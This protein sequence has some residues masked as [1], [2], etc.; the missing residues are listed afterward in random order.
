MSTKTPTK[1]KTKTAAITAPATPP[2]IAPPVEVIAGF[3]GFNK[4]LICHPDGAKPFQYE[5][6][7][8]YTHEGEVKACRQG[9]H[10]C[11]HPLDVFG[12][13]PPRT[14]R[15]AEVEG[16]GTP[17][18]DGS[19]TK[20]ATRTLTIKAEIG[21]P[22]LVRAAIEYV[23]TRCKPIDPES[24]ASATG[25]H[26]AA[27]ATGA[28]GAASATGDQGAASATGARGAASATGYQGAASATSY[29]G[30]AS[31]T[32]YQGAA[33]ATSY[34]GAA[35][36]TG[37]QGAASATGARGAASATGARGAASA[38]G[39]NSAA[40][41]S[42]YRGKAMGADGCALFLVERDDNYNIVAVWAGI[43]GRDG[44]KPMTWYVLTDGKPVEV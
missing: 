2:V 36:A 31:A 24:P 23:T 3:K 20:V 28:R 6:G 19:D 12:Y 42:G 26:G 39:D 14:S 17:S 21:I 40:M 4:D 10:F 8:T 1:R 38:T 41:A 37:D 22:G 16:S 44:I 25:D 33:S 15:Y 27:S 29:Q 30:A 43:A 11:E 35:S 13:Y 34:Q 5:V 9:F 7:Q 32:G 18:R